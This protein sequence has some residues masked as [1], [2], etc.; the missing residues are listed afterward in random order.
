MFVDPGEPP[1]R[2]DETCPICRGSCAG[3]AQNGDRLEITCKRC[4]EFSISRTADDLLDA[5]PMSP[6][7]LA[8][9]SG[10]VREHPQVRITADDLD[11]LFS[12]STPSASERADKLLKVVGGRTAALGAAVAVGIDAISCLEWLGITWSMNEAEL[13]YLV[14]NILHPTRATY[15]TRMDPGRGFLDVVITPAGYEYLD[16]LNRTQPDSQIGFCAMWFEHRMQSVWTDAIE[17]AILTAGYEPKR[18]D[19]HEHNNKIDD[20]I[21]ALIRR[22][23]FIVADCTGNRG[24]VYFEAGLALGLGLPVFW[25]CR[26]DRLHR[27]HFD[28]RQYNFVLWQGENLHDFRSRLQNRI[29]ATIGHGKYVRRSMS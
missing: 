27:V 26:A 1:M 8:N 24:G 17:P 3:Q 22:S 21:V 15:G 6:R 19:R 4:G 11:N 29:E 7:Q 28:T 25:T 16:H 23:R 2:T 14:R 18:V 13:Q 9:A 20:E 5:N 12:I 10:W